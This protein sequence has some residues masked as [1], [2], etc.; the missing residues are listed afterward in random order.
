MNVANQMEEAEKT[1]ALG[2]KVGLLAENENEVIA[3]LVRF[4]VV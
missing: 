3:T 4:R 1:Q 2:K